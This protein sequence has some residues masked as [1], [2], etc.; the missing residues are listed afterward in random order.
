MS[1]SLYKNSSESVIKHSLNNMGEAKKKL[2]KRLLQRELS[3]YNFIQNVTNDIYHFDFFSQKLNL[4][5][6]LDSYSYCFDE[7]YNSDKIKTL[8]IAYKDIK[9]IKLTDYQIIIDTDQV[10]RH[11]K[12]E[13]SKNR[14]NNNIFV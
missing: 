6:Q 7:T 4:G 1:I 8:N 10:I 12:F 5:I 11:L 13:L 14:I 3:E 9:V 2:W